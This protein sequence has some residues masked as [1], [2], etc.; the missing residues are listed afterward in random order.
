LNSKNALN[1]RYL[2]EK[3]EYIIF[4]KVNRDGIP[5]YNIVSVLLE[6]VLDKAYVFRS[7]LPD[8][9]FGTFYSRRMDYGKEWFCKRL[10]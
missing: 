6:R 10:V 9:H 7:I 2:S 1:L 3:E 8:E 5:H 4:W